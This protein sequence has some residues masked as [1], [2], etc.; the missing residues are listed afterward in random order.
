MN[1]SEFIDALSKVTKKTKIECE[2]HLDAFMEV[3]FENIGTKDGVKLTGF[4]AFSVSERSERM[5][6]NPHSGKEMLIPTRM[7]PAFKASKDLKNHVNKKAD[8]AEGSEEMEPMT[9]DMD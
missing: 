9:A 3:V 1:K 4:G 8:A 7:V 2:K 6:R 5:G